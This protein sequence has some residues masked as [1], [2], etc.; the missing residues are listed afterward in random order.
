MAKEIINA[1]KFN[2]N[3]YIYEITMTKAT[4]NIKTRK[5]ATITDIKTKLCFKNE[6]V[7]KWPFKFVSLEIKMFS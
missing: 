3:A 2:K 1:L 4:K 5:E 6:G 7:V